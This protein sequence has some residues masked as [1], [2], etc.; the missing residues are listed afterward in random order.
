MHATTTAGGAFLRTTGRIASF[1]A[2]IFSVL[3]AVV[4]IIGPLA[5]GSQ[6]Y[7]V[8]TNSMKPH[9]GPGTFLV[10]K[11]TAFDELA[12][13]DV[14]TYQLESG[15]PE[16][17]THRITSVAVDQEGDSLLVTKG[18]NNDVADPAPVAEIQVRGKLLYAVPFAGYA[19]NWFGNQDRGLATKLAA[20]ALIGYGA[21][22]MTR[23]V[24]ARR[25]N[26]RQETA[27]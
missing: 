16:V 10:V 24:I 27:A 3:A 19:A 11:P 15:R 6:T 14:V 20:L 23:A 9:Y 12:V 2:L 7:S 8:L 25:T 26:R 17:I 5:T 22:S 4:L 1:T 18:D 21:I 13:G